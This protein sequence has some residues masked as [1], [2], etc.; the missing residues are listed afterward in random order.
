M[1]PYIKNVIAVVVGWLGGSALNA[2]LVILGHKLVSGPEGH[3][4]TSKEGLRAA[5]PYI[6]IHHMIFP[7]LAHALGTLV[8]AFIATKLAGDA[9]PKFC[10]L[11]IGF[12]FLIGGIMMTQMIPQPMW[13]T[14][15]DLVFAY[16]PM[17]LLGYKLAGGDRV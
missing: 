5:M 3:D 8:G 4:M 16:I 2:G 14:I 1:H 7:F 9:H 11:F 6:E 10:A 17:A 12:F 15:V 13:F